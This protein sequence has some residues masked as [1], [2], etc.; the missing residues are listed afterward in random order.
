MCCQKFMPRTG[1][2]L[3]NNR[4][5]CRFCRSLARWSKTQ[6]LPPRE[7]PVE[8]LEN[9]WVGVKEKAIRAAIDDFYSKYEGQSWK[10]IISIGDS[11]FERRATI[12]SMER[13]AS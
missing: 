8:E 2:F 11:Q 7:T 10:N 3:E 13:Y 1:Q 9:F 12:R 5:D 6:K 4:I